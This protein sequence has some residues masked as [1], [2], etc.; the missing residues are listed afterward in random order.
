M[1]T[2]NINLQ[3]SKYPITIEDKGWVYGVWYCGTSFVPAEMYGQHPPTYLKR[4]FALFPDA[5]VWL[6]APSGVLAHGETDGR[7]HHTVDLISRKEGCPEFISSCD[8]LPFADE[9]M[10][11]V[12]TD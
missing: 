6:H 10:D 8:N 4:L 5:K 12:E 9:S 7:I 11:I 2:D 3:L 1:N